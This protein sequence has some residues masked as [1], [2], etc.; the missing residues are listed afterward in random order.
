[1]RLGEVAYPRE[2]DP[3]PGAQFQ[4]PWRCAALENQGCLCRNIFLERLS[5]QGGEE[6]ERKTKRE[7]ERKKKKERKRK[8]VDG[9][10]EGREQ[11][12]KVRRDGGNK[13]TKIREKEARRQKK[14]DRRKR[15]G[16]SGKKKEES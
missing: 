4:K 7:N 5:R 8:G 16:G 9:T 3:L 11:A 12:T 13:E 10:K 1:M 15:E 2:A 6:R 14:R